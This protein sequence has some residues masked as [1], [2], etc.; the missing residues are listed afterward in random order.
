MTQS[1]TS[2]QAGQRILALFGPEGGLT[3]QEVAAMTA[4][5]FQAVGLGPRIL[6]TE[7]APLYFLAATSYQLE[8]QGNL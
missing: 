5:G 7:T 6:R 4:A 8:L 3:S 1:L 2:L